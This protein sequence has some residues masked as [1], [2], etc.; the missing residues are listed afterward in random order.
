MSIWIEL[1]ELAGS[2]LA[3]VWHPEWVKQ[4]GGNEMSYTE[5]INASEV[6]DQCSAISEQH[7]VL[8][9]R[10]QPTQAGLIAILNGYKWSSLCQ[11]R[12]HILKRFFHQTIS[13]KEG[14]DPPLRLTVDVVNEAGRPWYVVHLGPLFICFVYLYVTSS[15]GCFKICFFWE[16]HRKRLYTR[17]G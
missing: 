4:V 12:C 15:H 16:E 17:P 5:L 14:A 8:L 11:T 7:Q 1:M 6:T 10:I 3:C 9:C 2:A 13:M